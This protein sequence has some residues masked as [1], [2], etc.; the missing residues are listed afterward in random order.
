MA[1]KTDQT[2]ANRMTKN[3]A[4]NKQ[5][6]ANVTGPSTEGEKMLRT[7]RTNKRLEQQQ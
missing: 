2:P 3:K 7:N 4:K 6:K 1:S 5:T